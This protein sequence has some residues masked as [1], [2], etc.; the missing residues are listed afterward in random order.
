MPYGE[1]RSKTETQSRQP[2]PLLADLKVIIKAANLAAIVCLVAQLVECNW[3][4]Q[5]ANWCRLLGKIPDFVMI[6]GVLHPV[7]E[8]QSIKVVALSQ[9]ASKAAQELACHLPTSIFGHQMHMSGS[10][11]SAPSCRHRW[12][13]VCL[14]GLLDHVRSHPRFCFPSRL[15]SLTESQ[16]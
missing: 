8:L 10:V 3:L 1:A 4:W 9:A 16:H 12:H 7:S 13:L 6:Q 5:Q 2:S 14:L 11:V 15:F